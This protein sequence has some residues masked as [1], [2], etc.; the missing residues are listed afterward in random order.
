MENSIV[1]VIKQASDETLSQQIE[2][3]YDELEQK[4]FIKEWKSSELESGHFVESI[5]RLI[6]FKLFGQYTPIGNNL[7]NFNVQELTRYEN[8]QGNESYRIIIPRVLFSVYCIRNKRG[9]GHLSLI[10]ANH[11]DATFIL[12]S[13][14]WVIAEIVRLESSLDPDKTRLLVDKIIQR[15][16][17]GL[18]EEGD[19]KRIL[20]DGINLKDSILFLLFDKSPQSD[21][22]MRK[23]IEYGDKTY[24]RKVL[25]DLHKKRLIEYQANGQCFLSPLGRKSA[26]TI[27]LRAFEKKE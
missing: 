6:E 20:I 1:Q 23:I 22:A 10:S 12:E 17:E 24:F 7:P 18:W 15:E 3:A 25:N 8:S 5:R 27:T 13:C 21:E 14:K 4:Y 11:Q 2:K 9:I 19:I 16:I 26:E